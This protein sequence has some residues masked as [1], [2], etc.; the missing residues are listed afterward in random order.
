MTKTT[1]AV[2]RH[3]SAAWRFVAIAV[4]ACCVLTAVGCASAANSL[5]NASFE[6]GMSHVRLNLTAHGSNVLRWR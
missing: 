6:S 5:Q 2:K 3:Q 1:R 4:A